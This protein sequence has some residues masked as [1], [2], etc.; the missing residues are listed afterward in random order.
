MDIDFSDWKTLL[1][2]TERILIEGTEKTFEVR[3]FAT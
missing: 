2:I 1:D 3:L